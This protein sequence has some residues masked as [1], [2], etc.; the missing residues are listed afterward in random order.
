MHLVPSTA[1]ISML[2]LALGLSAGA[3]LAA[4][5]EH[6]VVAPDAIEWQPG[7]DFIEPGAELALLAGDPAKGA[8]T[9]RLRLPAGY[10]IHSHYHTGAKYLTV[11]SGS[12]YIGFGDELDKS[13]GQKVPEGSF[14]KVPPHHRHYEWFEEETVLQVHVTEPFE[15]I[16]VDPDRDPRNR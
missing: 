10:D 16:Y 8:F 12:L 7:P 9:A 1:T 14:V 13:A 11:V 3:A 2:A 5:N 4:G 6:R 15:V